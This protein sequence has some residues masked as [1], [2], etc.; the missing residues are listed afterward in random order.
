[1]YCNLSFKA[2]RINQSERMW[3]HTE[4]VLEL[5]QSPRDIRML[6]TGAGGWKCV[7]S[8]TH[9][10]QVTGMPT[11]PREPTN[12]Y[13]CPYTL[14]QMV[15]IQMWLTVDWIPTWTIF[16]V[17]IGWFLVWSILGNE[18][19]LHF[20]PENKVWAYS[21]DIEGCLGGDRPWLG[22]T[23]STEKGK[24]KRA[25]ILFTIY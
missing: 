20:K 15:Q 21:S 9:N 2:I 6:V 1:M 14:R 23:P 3:F 22:S 16:E 19:K 17:N 8:N 4:K 18:V 13:T 12:S 7:F 10:Q 11:Q 25:G 5:I 24:L